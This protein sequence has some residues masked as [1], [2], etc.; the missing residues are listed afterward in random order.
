[1]LYC[2]HLLPDEEMAAV[3]RSAP[4][5][6]ESI[7]FSVAD[8]LDNLEATL[9]SYDRR[10]SRWGYPELLLH[11]PFLDLSPVDFDRE[12]RRVTLVRYELAYIAAKKLGTR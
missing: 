2:S 8:N 10:L 7:E 11:G 3:L 12:S 4:L 1:M 9:C 5:G 6:V